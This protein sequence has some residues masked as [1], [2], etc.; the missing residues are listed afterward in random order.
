MFF[1]GFNVRKPETKLIPRSNIKNIPCAVQ[2]RGNRVDR[3]DE[4]QE[5]RVQGTPEFQT[6]STAWQ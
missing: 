6:K 2:W 4:D 1:C 5:P 3:V